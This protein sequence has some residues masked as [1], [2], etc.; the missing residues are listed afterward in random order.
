MKSHLWIFVNALIENPAFDSQARPAGAKHAPR[1]A[2]AS[3][4]MLLLLRAQTKETLT[5]KASS[6]GSKCEISE[7]FMKKARRA[8]GVC[9]CACMH[10]C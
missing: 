5:T 7:E 4:A 10:A 9:A 2:R 1:C 6:F 8:R 3:D